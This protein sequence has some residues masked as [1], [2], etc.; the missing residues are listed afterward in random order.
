MIVDALN[1]EA[2][3][4][5][6][7]SARTQDLLDLALPCIDTLNLLLTHLLGTSIKNYSNLRLIH[8]IINI[9]AISTIMDKNPQAK[10]ILRATINTTILWGQFRYFID[11]Y[12]SVFVEN[13][14]GLPYK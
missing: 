7:R 6:K 2:F 8:E 4:V 5:S 13:L 3:D 9:H 1:E 12:L 10:R 14:F 11:M